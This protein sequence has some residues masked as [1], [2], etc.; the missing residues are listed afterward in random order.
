MMET[1]MGSKTAKMKESL[2]A[3]KMVKMMVKMLVV[4]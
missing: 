4:T 3:G 2:M 1:M